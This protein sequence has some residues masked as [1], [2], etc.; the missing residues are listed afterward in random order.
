MNGHP[1]FPLGLAPNSFCVFAFSG[2]A[3]R[4]LVLSIYLS[5]Q[6]SWTRINAATAANQRIP[7]KKK[8]VTRPCSLRYVASKVARLDRVNIPKHTGFIRRRQESGIKER[9]R[10]IWLIQTVINGGCSLAIH[11]IRPASGAGK[12]YRRYTELTN[13]LVCFY[14]IIPRPWFPSHSALM[15]ILLFIWLWFI[16]FGIG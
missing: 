1:L 3:K 12:H 15:A 13:T 16:S 14:M 7:K 11:L 9:G 8:N 5:A 2:R 10:M 6:K 4:N